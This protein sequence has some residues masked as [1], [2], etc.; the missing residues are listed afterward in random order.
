MGETLNEKREQLYS[1]NYKRVYIRK[2]F[3]SNTVLPTCNEQRRLQPH[4]RFR[5]P[6]FLLF[7]LPNLG[8]QRYHVYFQ[9][10]IL[11][12]GPLCSILRNTVLATTIRPTRTRCGHS[13]TS[14]TRRRDSSTCP[15]S[16]SIPNWSAESQRQISK[17]DY[18]IL[19]RFFI[20]YY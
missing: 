14:S 7:R 12:G 20:T 19:T 1:Y 18:F 17:S 10:S 6:K 16:Y 13:Q 4:G 15:I 8:G 9:K 3:M 5:Q 11:G 2:N